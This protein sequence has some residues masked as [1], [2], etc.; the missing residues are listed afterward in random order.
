MLEQ[1]VKIPA[2]GPGSYNVFV[3]SRMLHSL[4]ARIEPDLTRLA[5]FV[6][7]DQN[8]VSAGHLST[9]LGSADPSTFIITPPGETSKN[10]ATVVSIVEAMEDACLGR[11]SLIVALGGGTVGDVAAFAA[12]IFK[13]G[14]PVVRIPTTTVAQADSAIGGKTGVDSS[15]SKNAFGAFWHPGAVYVDV[16]TLA[17]LD[18]RHFR[19]GL[20][21]SV[22]HAVIADADYFDF[23]EKNLDG[24]LVRQLDLLEKMACFNC[25]IKA[26]VV[27]ADPVEKNQRRMLNYGHTIGHAVEAASGYQLLHGEAVAIGI[28]AAGLIEIELG[29]GRQERLDRVRKMLERIGGPVTLP[30]NLAEKNLIELVKHDKKAVAAWPRFVLI[31][32]IGRVHCR[33]GQYAVPVQ[34]EIVY[35]V[36]TNLK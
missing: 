14:V 16:A 29:L 19:A 4:W 33:D 5:R 28:I 11:D 18:D 15:K 12:S 8:L 32:E 30:P 26:A 22:K 35:K 24:I 20:V 36:L 6:V 9:L 34:L 23:L 2:S 25:T 27:E 31:S 17:T 10:M 1:N 13:R 21:E 7:T 3:G